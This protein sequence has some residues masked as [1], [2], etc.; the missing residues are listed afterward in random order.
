M[1]TDNAVLNPAEVAHGQL[2]EVR[3]VLADRS[4]FTPT[5]YSQWR[6]HGSNRLV[7]AGY[8]YGEPWAKILTPNGRQTLHHFKFTGRDREQIEQLLAQ[9]A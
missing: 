6:Q 1:S 8:V 7:E 9:L 5:R 2:R 4:R 3:A